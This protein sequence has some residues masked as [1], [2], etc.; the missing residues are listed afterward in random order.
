MSNKVELTGRY[1]EIG[2]LLQQEY[3]KKAAEKGNTA[4]GITYKGGV[5]LAVEKNTTSTIVD[6]SNSTC[7]SLLSSAYSMTYSGLPHD[8]N[9]VAKLMKDFTSGYVRQMEREP[10]EA[11]F[12]STLQE[13]LVSFGSYTGLRPAGCEFLVSSVHQD[14]ACLYHLDTFGSVSRCSAYS[15]GLN[16][17]SAK[18][19]LEKISFP[20]PSLSDAIQCAA[21]VFFLSRDSMSEGA[22]EVEMAFADRGS[23]QRRVDPEV[24]RHHVNECSVVSM[25]D[26]PN[27]DL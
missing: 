8:N 23:C 18:T 4:I 15:T 9:V 21:R 10:P 27:Q 1:T 17:K 11:L 24:V 22:F 26:E 12:L 7:T 16:S 6:L 14:S 25:H 19:E 13:Y 3:A 20:A 5:L 2:A